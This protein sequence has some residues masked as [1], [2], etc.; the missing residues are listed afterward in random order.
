MTHSFI[1]NIL[2]LIFLQCLILND[3]RLPVR[4]VSIL[5]EAPEACMSN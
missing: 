1:W 2:P 3:S 4:M 5:H